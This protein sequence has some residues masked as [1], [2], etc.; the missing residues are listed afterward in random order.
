MPFQ[1]QKSSRFVVLIRSVGLVVDIYPALLS[2]IAEVPFRKLLFI[3]IPKSGVLD[4]SQQLR[5][6]YLR[7]LGIGKI[8]AYRR[9]YLM[10]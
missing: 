2:S 7:S 8:C 4:C 10:Q 9:K 1:T 5:L 6:I 3:L